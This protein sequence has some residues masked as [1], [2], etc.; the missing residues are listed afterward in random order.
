MTINIEINEEQTQQFKESQA[1]QIQ[2]ET[3][4]K[5]ARL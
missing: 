1:E 4:D 2:T 3:R 5:I